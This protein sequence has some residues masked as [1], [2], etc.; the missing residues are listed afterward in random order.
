MQPPDNRGVDWT[1]VGP[2]DPPIAPLDGRAFLAR[3]RTPE[4]PER[5][6]GP[7]KDQQGLFRSLRDAGIAV[8]LHAHHHDEWI[9]VD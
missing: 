6:R 9:I 8:C 7:P 1:G 5:K 4:P 3:L 2:D